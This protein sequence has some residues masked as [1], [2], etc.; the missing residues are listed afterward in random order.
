MKKVIFSG[1]QPTGDLHL[2]NYLG[3]I[4]HWLRLQNQNSDSGVTRHR[5]ELQNDLNCELI[6]CIV[7]LHAL[8]IPQDPIVLREKILQLS[9]LYIACG[10]DPK[11]SNIFIQSQNPDHPYLAWI[12]DCLLTMGE[13]SRMTQYKDK[14]QKQKQTTVGLFNY[15]ALMAADV[16]LYDTDLVPVG[17]DQYQHLELA[18]DVAKKFNNKFGK[19]DKIFTIPRP[20]E[21]KNPL[22]IMSLSDPA[23]KMSKSE[24]DPMGTIN[25]LDSPD[26]IS[27]K[28]SRAMTDSGSDIIYDQEKKPAIS[29]MLTIYSQLSNTDI[30]KI[31]S[32]YQSK[33][34]AQF[35]NDLAEVVIDVFRPIQAHYQ[36]IL[37]DQKYLKQ[38]LTHG[39]EY[40]RN[41]SSKKITQI[42][43]SLGL[44]I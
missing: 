25:I 21:Q 4:N 17:E 20:L 24:S 26:V 9:A 7:D 22:R 31:E 28:I 10:I 5:Q 3:A 2:G 6:F 15:P 8:T 43:Q 34:Y 1:I 16:L 30:S 41:K 42:K 33:G 32:N 27:K 23:K 12:I 37:S 44:N 36:Q 38:I 18:R 29:N 14:K 19:K 11:K 39:L 13:L 35:K 40:A